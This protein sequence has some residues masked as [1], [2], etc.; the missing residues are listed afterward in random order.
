[1]AHHQ[2]QAEPDGPEEDEL[3]VGAGHAV[4]LGMVGV[5]GAGQAAARALLLDEAL[6]GEV[7]GLAGELAGEEEGDLGLARGP[8]QRGVDDAQGLRK[9]G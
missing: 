9:E 3:G 5:E 8:E 7:G 1:M 6:E 4:A 2:E